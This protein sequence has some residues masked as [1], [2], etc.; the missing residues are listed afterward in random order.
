M[1]KTLL[2]KLVEEYYGAGKSERVYGRLAEEMRLVGRSTW[3]PMWRCVAALRQE[4]GPENVLVLGSTNDSLLACLLGATSVTPLPPPYRCTNCHYTT[5]GRDRHAD[6]RDTPD[7]VCPA[8]GG[9]MESDGHRLSSRSLAMRLPDIGLRVPDEMRQLV[10]DFIPDYW[11]CMDEDGTFT[12]ESYSDEELTALRLVQSDGQQGIIEIGALQDDAPTLEGLPPLT[13]TYH[14][15]KAMGLQLAEGAWSRAE[16][17]AIH[18]G[19]VDFL[20]VIAFREDVY[21]LIRQHTPPKARAENGIPWQ[22]IEAVRKGKYA[23]CGMPEELKRYLSC[24]LRLPKYYISA[25]KR[26][27]YL[28]RKGDCVARW[29]MDE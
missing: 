7:A 1:Q 15:I 16:Q 23:R 20:D 14:H 17:I 4:F 6:S 26:I 3:I 9:S 21:D 29:M 12:V 18:R 11:Q 25:L 2:V 24:T 8:C 5:F 13:T 22:I 28:P 27:E 10:T 19:D